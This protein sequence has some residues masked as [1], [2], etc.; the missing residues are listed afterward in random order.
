MIATTVMVIMFI[1]VAVAISMGSLT[2]NRPFVFI[3]SVITRTV[4]HSSMGTQYKKNKIDMQKKKKRISD[5]IGRIRGWADQ[6]KAKIERLGAI[7][8]ELAEP[9]L[10][11]PINQ[12]SFNLVFL[13]QNVQS[14]TIR[15]MVFGTQIPYWQCNWTHWVLQ[16]GR[17][18]WTPFYGFKKEYAPVKDQIQNN[19][20]TELLQFHMTGE[21]CYQDAH[22]E[23]PGKS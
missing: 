5:P 22:H 17:N 7:I 20:E 11:P 8:S 2:R 10:A 14:K 19:C 1:R 18:G 13:P 12:L 21:G 16:L 3:I 23:T 4:N 9:F 15:S 6:R